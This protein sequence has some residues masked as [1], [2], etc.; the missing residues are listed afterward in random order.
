MMRVLSK[1]LLTCLV[2][3]SVVYGTDELTGDT[4][5]ACEAILCLSSSERPGECAPSLAKYFSIT[6]K[7]AHETIRKR[8]NFLKL[9]P[10]DET[11]KVDQ[12]YASLIDTLSEVGGGCDANTLNKNLEKRRVRIGESRIRQTQ[13]RVNPNMPEYCV[14]LAR[15][16]YTNIKSIKYT[17]DTKFYDMA[18]W[19]RGYELISI[20]QAIYNTL[21]SDKKEVQTNPEYT[22]CGDPDRN[23]YWQELCRQNTPQYFFFEKKYF[24]KV[25]W[26]D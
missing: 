13:I 16:N 22:K 3:S 1:I 24:S 9:C 23:S 10:T 20:N 2:S 21:P 19:N 15:H 17:C 26:V 7:K 12:N 11:A 8:K 4:K 14:R 25:C 18:S 5:L 6:A